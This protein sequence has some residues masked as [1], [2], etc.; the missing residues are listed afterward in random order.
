MVALIVGDRCRWNR[1]SS[2]GQVTRRISAPVRVLANPVLA[3]P[4]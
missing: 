3:F 2:A 4:A 1:P